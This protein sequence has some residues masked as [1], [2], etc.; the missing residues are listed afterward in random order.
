MGFVCENGQSQWS[1]RKSE[2]IEFRGNLWANTQYFLT[3]AASEFWRIIHTRTR[4]RVLFYYGHLCFFLSRL[5]TLQ[6]PLT[7]FAWGRNS[8]VR[9]AL[10]CIWGPHKFSIFGESGSSSR[11]MTQASFIATCLLNANRLPKHFCA[12]WSQHLPCR[13][14]SLFIAP[15]WYSGAFSRK[16]TFLKIPISFTPLIPCLLPPRDEREKTE[17]TT[18]QLPA[19]KKCFLLIFAIAIDCLVLAAIPASFPP[20][21]FLLA[22][23]LCGVPETLLAFW[24]A[25][26]GSAREI[27]SPLNLKL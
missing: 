7:P 5:P 24:G 17:R 13:C 23:L 2:K 3:K 11:L 10:F 15:E 27:S 8:C 12:H 19:N 9:F 22:V 14:F 1:M 25:L 18:A 26:C 16:S 20:F 6:S 21:P 4:M